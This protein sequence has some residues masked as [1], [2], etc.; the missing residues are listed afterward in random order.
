MTDHISHENGIIPTKE[1][2]LEWA[3]ILKVLSSGYPGHVDGG[4]NT[5]RSPSAD[6]KVGGTP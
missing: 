2:R 4:D 3:C 5:Q 1:T 6:A